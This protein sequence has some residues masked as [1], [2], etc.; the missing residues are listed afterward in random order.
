MKRSAT[1]FSF[2]AADSSFAIIKALD[3]SKPFGG[4]ISATQMQTVRNFG[5]SRPVYAAPRSTIDGGSKHQ[6]RL[7]RF[8][9]KHMAER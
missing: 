2:L 4:A 3:P 9:V 5:S 7:I 1:L 8:I 6:N